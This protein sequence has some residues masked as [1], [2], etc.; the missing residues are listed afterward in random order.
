MLVREDIVSPVSDAV[1]TL[2][3]LL[4]ASVFSKSYYTDQNFDVFPINYEGWRWVHDRF[5]QPPLGNEIRS[6]R[7]LAFLDD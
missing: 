4:W 6:T 3:S 5:Y 1:Y 2:Q 7:Q